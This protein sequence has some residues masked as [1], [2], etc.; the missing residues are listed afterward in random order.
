LKIKEFYHEEHEEH[1]GRLILKNINPQISY[2]QL[3][4]FIK[5][6][7]NRFEI[8]IQRSPT[9]IDAQPNLRVSTAP[10]SAIIGQFGIFIVALPP[11]PFP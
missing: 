9:T 10:Q 6:L 7:F 2:N 8:A 3:P 4:A 11:S 1:E 5:R